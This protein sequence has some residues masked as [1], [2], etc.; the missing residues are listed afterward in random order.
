MYSSR[1]L[2]QQVWSCLTTITVQYAVGRDMIGLTWHG[3]RRL[4]YSNY[5]TFC[6]RW[7]RV[8][9]NVYTSHMLFQQVRRCMATITVQYAV[10]QDMTRLRLH[11]IRRLTDS[12]YDTAKQHKLSNIFAADGDETCTVATCY[13]NKFG[14]SDNNHDGPAHCWET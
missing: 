5:A 7:R 4:T 2:F 12:K 9:R 8:T 3:I 1:M 6:C 11:G 10:G 13:F 14:V